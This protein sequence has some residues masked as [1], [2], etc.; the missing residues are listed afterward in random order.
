MDGWILELKQFQALG[1]IRC[2]N[3]ELLGALE[4]PYLPT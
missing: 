1:V 2:F 4:I 3:T